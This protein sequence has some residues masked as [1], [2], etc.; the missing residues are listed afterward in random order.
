MAIG[1]VRSEGKEQ[2]RVALRSPAFEETDLDAARLRPEREAQRRGRGILRGRQ[3]AHHEEQR[4]ARLRGQVQP[5]QVFPA[6]M[7]LP[8]QQL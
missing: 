6:H 4:L 8:E 3:R 5:A 7:V 2:G 1:Q